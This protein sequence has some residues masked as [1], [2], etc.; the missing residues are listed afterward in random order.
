MVRV[1]WRL[2][3]LSVQLV[4][5]VAFTRLI[6]GTIPVGETWFVA[7][8]L[9]IVINRQLLEP[10]YPRPGDV[11]ANSAVGITI[12]LTADRSRLH[13]GWTALF[14]GLLV[15]GCLGLLALAGAGRGRSG[16]TVRVARAAQQIAQRATAQVIYSAVFLVSLLNYRDPVTRDFWQLSA[17]WFVLVSVG[18]I[19]WQRAWSSV[20][21][22]GQPAVVEGLIG[23]ARL[24]VS[25][26]EA[27]QV[28]HEVEVRGSRTTARGVVTAR[29][30]RKND[31]WAEVHLASPE[32]AESLLNQRAVDLRGGGVEA[33][34]AGIVDEGSTVVSLSFVAAQALQ[35]GAVVGV[36]TDSG[37]VL[38]QVTQGRIEEKAVRGGAHLVVRAQANQLGTFDPATCRLVQHGWVV[39]PGSPVRLVENVD[40]TATPPDHFLRLGTVLHTQIPIYLD[41]DAMCEGHAA[42]LGMTKMGKST[43][44]HRIAK[45]IGVRRKTVVLDGT[46]EYLAK[47][48]VSPFNKDSPWT[49]PS[50]SVLEAPDNVIRPDFALKCVDR[51]MEL[52]GEEY[53][54]GDPTPRTL[55]FEEAHDF[56]PEPASLGFNAPG[57]DSSYTLGLRM[58]QIRKYGVSF[59]LVSQR[60]AV[61]SK[62]A[63]S[64]CENL[65]VFRSVDRTGLDYLED[66]SGADVRRLIPALR[67]GEAVVF[68]PAV[69]ADGPVAIDVDLV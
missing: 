42:V 67:Q 52:G 65:I 39:P 48:D 53:A 21:A 34:F 44:T 25:A 33:E 4:A 51:L 19:N 35:V 11:V 9:A 66:V 69:S 54:N 2:G 41:L 24:L 63:L 36:S 55:I 57:R 20:H 27:P 10:Y 45:A 13:P 31:V 29:I 5:L 6:L 60:T 68:G 18:A 16:P 47:R 50:L 56:F 59:V 62:S 40:A 1:Q 61:V 14:V 28:G 38:F 49:D 15:A 58:M 43:L 23:P 7:G 8:L 37:L 3:V 30:R 32:D 17:L 46:G 22:T 26:P 64:Q 12:W